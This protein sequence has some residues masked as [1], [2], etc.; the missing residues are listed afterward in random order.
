MEQPFQWGEVKGDI[1]ARIDLVQP[2]KSR[3]EGVLDGDDLIVQWGLMKP[4][5]I[6]KIS[7]KALGR[8]IDV[9]SAGLQYG[10]HDLL[11]NGGVDFSQK[12]LKIDMDAQAGDLDWDKILAL[13]K[14]EKGAEEKQEEEGKEKSKEQ[15][16]QVEG[17][18]QL[19]ADSFRYE[20]FTW[21]PLHA[22]FSMDGDRVGVEV[23][24]ESMMCGIS[25]PGVLNVKGGEVSLDFKPET[26]DLSIE[27]L[28]NCMWSDRFRV[29]GTMDMQ[30]EIRAK[31]K[32]DQ[33]IESLE[34]FINYDARKGRIYRDIV[35][36]N[37]LGF[38]NISEI[39]RGRFPQIGEEGFAYHSVRLRSTI[40]EGKLIVREGIMDGEPADIA[41][42]G[43]FDLAKP[44]INLTVLVSPVKTANWIIRHTPLVR[45]IMGGNLITVPVRVTGPPDNVKVE[46]IPT[47]M[48]GGGVLEM[49][50]RTVE[51]PFTL[52]HANPSGEK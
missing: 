41:F 52:I 49:M 2:L 38:L 50:K 18:V 36:S 11:L 12:G 20:Q 19:K 28:T 14:Q 30:A 43:K 7:L 4:I 24:K 44:N 10:D 32:P 34:G 25:T 47:T 16:L 23:K 17:T 13:I 8:H 37:V 46:P 29:T 3:A 35:V 42:E 6:D 51:L 26:K 1:N 31:G 40:K 45:R 48:V 27:P 21:K 9:H 5:K 15:G 33:L 39:L 22:D